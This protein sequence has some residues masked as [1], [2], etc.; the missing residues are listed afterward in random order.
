MNVDLNIT[1]VYIVNKDLKMSKG[2]IAAQVSHVAM[3]MGNHYDKIGR[4]IVLKAPEEDMCRLIDILR[5]E[6]HLMFKINDAG[7]TEVPPGSLTCVGFKSSGFIK[8]LT[9]EFKLL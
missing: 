7:L 4:A 9:K 5:K 3:K 6:K 8:G 1:Y 2:K